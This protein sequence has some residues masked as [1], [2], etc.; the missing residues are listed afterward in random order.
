[1][2]LSGYPMKRTMN[3]ASSASAVRR[4]SSMQGI[5]IAIIL[6]LLG[7]PVAAWFDLQD[8]SARILQE[9]A[10]ETGRIIDQMR[11]F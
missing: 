9:Q 1:M 6:G 7:L 2:V 11:N 3:F 4:P 8:L 5:H 10:R